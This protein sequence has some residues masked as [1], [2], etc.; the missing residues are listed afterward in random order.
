MRLS[1][2]LPSS[3][4]LGLVLTIATACAG[5]TYHVAHDSGTYASHED[6]WCEDHQVY[7]HGDESMHGGVEIVIEEDVHPHHEVDVHVEESSGGHYDTGH[8]GY[9]SCGDFLAGSGGENDCNPGQYCKDATFS[10]CASGCLSDVNCA[11]HEVCEKGNYRKVG[12][13]RSTRHYSTR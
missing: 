6:D 3:A 5:G 2:L 12:S 4:L 11:G 7:H 8:S 1:T 9:T 10:K 13:C